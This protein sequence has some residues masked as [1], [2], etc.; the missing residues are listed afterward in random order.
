MQ[1]RNAGQVRR[2]K[3]RITPEWKRLIEVLHELVIEFQA[4]DKRVPAATIDWPPIHKRL[5]RYRTTKSPS[6]CMT[7]A[8]AFL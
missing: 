8:G 7:T 4:R 1:L 3:I 2:S 6:R 5:R